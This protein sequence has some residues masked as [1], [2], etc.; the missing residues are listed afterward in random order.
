MLT[1]IESN[2]L[3]PPPLLPETDH[4]YQLIE[5]RGLSDNT[6]KDFEALSEIPGYQWICESETNSINV[7]FEIYN[8]ADPAALLGQKFKDR[9]LSTFGKVNSS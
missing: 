6:W 5:S 7:W 4:H 1:S 8:S 3:P 9:R 2:S